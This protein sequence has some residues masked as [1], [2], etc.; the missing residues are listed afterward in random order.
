MKNLSKIGIVS[1]FLFSLFSGNSGAIDRTPTGFFYPT[2]NGSF[3]RN[4]CAS[5]L[6]RGEPHGCYVSKNTYHIGEDISANEGSSVY[7]IA[8]GEVVYVHWSDSSWGKD[9]ACVFV[10]HHLFEKGV[11]EPQYFIALYGHIRTDVKKGDFVYGGEAFAKIGPYYNGSHL[12]FGIYPG[13][14]IPQTNVSNGIGWG[15]IADKHYP[16]DMGYKDPI[17][18][19]RTQLPPSDQLTPEEALAYLECVHECSSLCEPGICKNP[20]RKAVVWLQSEYGVGGDLPSPISDLHISSFKIKLAGNSDSTLQHSIGVTMDYGKTLY[21]EGKLKVRNKGNQEIEDV[22]SD[23][24]VDDDKD[25]FSENDAKVDEDKPF[26]IKPG[27]KVTKRMRPVP[28]AISSDGKSV[29]VGKKTFPIHGNYKE[30]YFFSDVEGGGDKDIS[31][32]E[33]EFGEVRITTRVPNYA[34]VGF[35]DAYDCSGF[36]GWAKDDNFPEN[37][38]VIQPVVFDKNG[39]NGK[40]LSRF[41]A[42]HYRT[43][44]GNHGFNWSVPKNFKDGTPRLF[45]F[46]AINQPAGHNPLLKSSKIHNATKLQLTCA[47]AFGSTRPAYRFYNPS[48]DHLSH[49]F[50][51][52]EG[53]KNGVLQSGWRSEGVGWYAFSRREVNTVPVYRLF[54]FR[55]GKGH[56]YTASSSE[57]NN[58]ANNPDWRYEG[59]AFYAYTYRVKGS[60]PIYRLYHHGKKSHF[61][62]R[63]SGEKNS[64]IKGG[65]RYEG[66]AFYALPRIYR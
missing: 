11:E 23:Y 7:A 65:Y 30:I 8:D 32:N 4:I 20:N 35:V 17:A 25:D 42:D 58:I 60:V 51:I 53:E 62:T 2:G 63:F 66:V 9:N 27:E 21:F 18:Y 45:S 16:K 52:S 14:K 15:R 19:I 24:R 36:F 50:T 43:D 48:P 46:H 37:S 31:S 64:A 10:K 55:N 22:D 47:P 29:K 59:I 40:S 13:A 56:F 44:V 41:V 54:R 49:F 38:V 5:W 6:S 1:I 33:D 61:Y 28:V 12:H 39:Y 26:D 3:E 34:P 57:K